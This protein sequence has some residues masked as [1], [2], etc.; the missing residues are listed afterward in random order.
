MVF[1]LSIILISVIIYLCFVYIKWKHSYWMRHKIPFLKP[2]SVYESFK[3]TR[4]KHLSQEMALVYQKYKG[5]SPMLGLYFY[6]Q[7]VLLVTDLDLIRN[8]LITDFQYFQD[9]G[10]FY[11]QKDDPLSANLFRIE[12]EKWKPLRAKLM[13]TFSTAKIK[14]MLP[15]IL[16]IANELID[17]LNAAIKS[18]SEIEIYEWMGRYTIDTIGS[19]AFGIDCNSLNDPNTIFH[20]KSKKEFEQPKYGYTEAILMNT[21]RNVAKFLRIRLHH[22]DVT[23][24][25]MNCVKETIFYREENNVKR[26]DFMSL[27]IELKNSKNV[28]E[29]LTFNEI[30]AQAFVFFLGGFET[31]ATTLT[32]CLYELAMD[33]NKDIQNKARA[34]ILS[35]LEKY[36]GNLTFEA[37]TEMTY[38]E[39]I[40]NEAL[41]KHP[42]TSGNLLRIATK[43][44]NAPNMK[45][46]IPK[47]MQVLIPTYA[48]HHDPNIYEEPDKFNPDR[49]LPE[50]I[51]LRSPCTFLSFGDGARNCIGSKFGMFQARIALVKLLQNFEFSTCARTQIPM[52]YKIN[53]VILTP[54][55]GM[56]LKMQHWH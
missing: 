31:A 48:I 6:L 14:I 54:E 27:L 1:T 3:S 49:F 7:P 39:Q 44:Y 46:T 56:W 35:V 21:Y 41:R 38:I 26:N 15:T 51:K 24:F 23:D 47:G 17:C 19:C 5:K 50:Q 40:I 32:Y 53:H 36:N 13:P 45:F 34:E 29:K 12:Y 2:K 37:L 11:N 55:N 22:K 4:T 33:S 20:E 43:E 9:R 18:D 10:L 16:A 25:F 8:I 42:P 52:R 30:A 28:H